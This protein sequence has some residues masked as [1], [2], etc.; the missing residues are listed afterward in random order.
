LLDVRVDAVE[1]GYAHAGAHLWTEDGILLGMATQT[2]V[3][4]AVDDAGRSTRSTRRIV[5]SE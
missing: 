5:G 3:V 2:L 4:R 1:R